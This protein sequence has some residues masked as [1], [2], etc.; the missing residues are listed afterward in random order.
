M[1]AV[2]VGWAVQDVGIIPAQKPVRLYPAQTLVWGP[3]QSMESVLD[4]SQ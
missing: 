1:Q 2:Q 4:T 3:S